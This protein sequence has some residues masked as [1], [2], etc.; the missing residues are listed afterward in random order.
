MIIYPT[1]HSSDIHPLE[2]SATESETAAFAPSRG[3]EQ[4][5]CIGMNC[6]TS[7]KLR[8]KSFVL[9]GNLYLV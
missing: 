3:I 1:T 4:M 6:P 5:D 9:D 8:Y 7:A 2:I